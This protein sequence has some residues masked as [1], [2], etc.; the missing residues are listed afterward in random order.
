MPPG[1]TKTCFTKSCPRATPAGA[2]TRNGYRFHQDMRFRERRE[3]FTDLEHA[4]INTGLAID[5]ATRENGCLQVIRGSHRLGTS[6]RRLPVAR[7]ER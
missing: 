7:S 1:V 2:A 3:A 6:S 5:P 4:Y